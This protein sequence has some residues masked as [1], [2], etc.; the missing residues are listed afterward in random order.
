MPPFAAGF[1][2]AAPGVL[3][4]TYSYV[5][6][7]EPANRQHPFGLRRPRLSRDRP[8]TRGAEDSGRAEYVSASDAEALE[9]CTLLARTEGIIPALESAHAVAETLKRAPQMKNGD[10][11]GEH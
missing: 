9:A 4:G 3:Q 7:D 2:G 11:P 1:T 6:Q 8:R 10:D 5:L